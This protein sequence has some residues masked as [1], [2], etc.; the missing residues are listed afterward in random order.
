MRCAHRRN[1]FS[2]RKILIALA[3]LGCGT[4]GLVPATRAQTTQPALTA[5]TEPVVQS[6]AKAGQIVDIA[7]G[8]SRFLDAAWPVKK[9]AVADPSVADVD[10]VS[11]TRIQIRGKALGMT[12]LALEGEQGE[13]WHARIAVSADTTRLQNEL[14][15]LFPDSD[16]DV[17]QV[18]QVIVVKGR[19]AHAEDAAQLRELFK[20]AKLQ[21]L[22]LTSVAG[23]QQVQLQ[24][25]I[26]EVSRTAIRMLG[27]NAFYGG[28]QWFGGLQLGSSAGPFIPMGVGL[29][30]GVPVSPVPLTA[31]QTGTNGILNQP[32]AT[33][34]AG[35]PHSDLQVFVQAL[36]EN[37]YLRILAEPTLVAQR[38]K[39]TVPCRR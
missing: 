34:F 32:A 24:V 20:Q 25:K 28:N 3:V 14:R 26:A 15:K 7:I 2:S 13:S 23:L 8:E 27:V 37:Q 9:V 33:L 35:F 39:S 12:D 19:L 30:Q 36:E 4:L 18:D 10:A 11:P 5:T 1:R 16:L 6:A 29:P 31:Y 21:Y 38:T 22:D 17:A